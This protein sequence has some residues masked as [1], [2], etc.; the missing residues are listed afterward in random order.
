MW[1]RTSSTCKGKPRME[2]KN[3]GSNRTIT[4][5]WFLKLHLIFYWAS[6]KKLQI[7]LQ[8]LNFGQAFSWV[9]SSEVAFLNRKGCAFQSGFKH[10]LYLASNGKKS[11]QLSI[12]S[13]LG[14]FFLKSV[15]PR[16]SVRLQTLPDEKTLVLYYKAFP[17]K[18]NAM[19]EIGRISGPGGSCQSP[20]KEP[21]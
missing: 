18:W 19:T 14:F 15:E 17:L 10:S 6:V 11:L 7:K 9:K 5:E 2:N 12:S 4:C 21:K 13:C 20:G 8:Y 3:T 1:D 16:V